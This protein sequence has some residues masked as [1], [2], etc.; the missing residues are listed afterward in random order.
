MKYY[1]A[2]KMK[3]IQVYSI[4]KMICGSIISK[5]NK[6]VSEDYI[7]YM[8]LSYKVKESKIKQY[9]PIFANTLGKKL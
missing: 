4:M 1:I 9:I 8:G 2:V 6:Q 7:E 5:G 3:K